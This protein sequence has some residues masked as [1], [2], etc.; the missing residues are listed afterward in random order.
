[1]F[2]MQYIRIWIGGARANNIFSALN[3]ALSKLHLIWAPLLLPSLMLMAAK[4]FS[5]LFTRVHQLLFC[6]RIFLLL[7][8]LYTLFYLLARAL[9]VQNMLIHMYR[10]CSRKISDF[11]LMAPEKNLYYVAKLFVS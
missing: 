1:M 6:Q 7:R 3:L 10:M 9:N 2:F 4:P 5:F 11:H 8:A